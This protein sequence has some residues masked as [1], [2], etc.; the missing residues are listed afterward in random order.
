M[1]SDRAPIM[2]SA[3][4]YTQLF[5]IQI[6]CPQTSIRHDCV[7]KTHMI[8]SVLMYIKNKKNRNTSFDSANIFRE[9]YHL[10][11]TGLHAE[12][13]QVKKWAAG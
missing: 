2:C 4:I 3:G 6:D 5:C 11:V 13:F 1:Y 8:L 12:C 10:A 7:I 9:L